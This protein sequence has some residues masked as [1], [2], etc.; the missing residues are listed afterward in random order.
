M[1]SALSGGQHNL[2]SEVSTNPEVEMSYV[3]VLPDP[4]SL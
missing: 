4:G 1:A 2:T 3:L